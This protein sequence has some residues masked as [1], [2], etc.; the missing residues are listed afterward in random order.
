[1]FTCKHYKYVYSKKRC[2]LSDRGA[3]L[4]LVVTKGNFSLNAS[5]KGAL[6]TRCDKNVIIHC[7][8]HDFFFSLPGLRTGQI[9]CLRVA[10]W[11]PFP[12]GFTSVCWNI[13]AE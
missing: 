1:V 10:G 9:S 11:L 6:A 7:V 13:T 4:S 5:L 8:P 2:W 12:L 3:W